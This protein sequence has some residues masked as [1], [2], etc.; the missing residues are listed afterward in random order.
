MWQRHSRRGA[1]HGCPE[2]TTRRW[3]AR[4]LRPARF[5]VQV[6]TACGEAAWA[7]LAGGVSPDAACADLVSAYAGARAT[8]AGQ[9]LAAVAA[10]IYRLQPKVRLMQ[11]QA[12]AG[13]A[14]A[15]GD[16]PPKSGR[17]ARVQPGP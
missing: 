16:D 5:L 15:E 1:G 7:A 9:H 3:G 12:F 10:L 4:W 6:L 2:R 11:P 14:A 17:S 8:P 13:T